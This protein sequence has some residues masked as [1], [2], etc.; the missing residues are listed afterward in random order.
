MENISKKTQ[1]RI[2][3]SLKRESLAQHLRKM[4]EFA[5]DNPKFIT[6]ERIFR[7]MLFYHVR[8]LMNFL[9]GSEINLP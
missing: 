5:I 1:L 7:C 4:E 6:C 9:E 3:P 2:P 8:L